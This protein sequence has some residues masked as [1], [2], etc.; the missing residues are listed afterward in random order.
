[1][2]SIIDK[3][4]QI[5]AAIFGKDVRE[6][7]ASGIEVI[8]SEVESTTSKQNNLKSQFDSLVINAGSSNAE[9]VAG[10]TSNTTGLTSDTIG[11]RIDGVDSQL[12]DIKN[13]QE[14]EPEDLRISISDTDSVLVQRAF[15]SCF[16]ENRKYKSIKLGRM[17]NIDTSIQITGSVAPFIFIK[18]NGGGLSNKQNNPMFIGA[19]AYAGGLHFDKVK[20][21][22]D[23]VYSTSAYFD[24]T[25]LIQIVLDGCQFMGTPT[26]LYSPTYLQSCR[27]INS[28]FKGMKDYQV[29][30]L[31][32]YDV[33][34]DNNLVEWGDGGLINLT[35]QGTTLDS[36]CSYGLKI[37]KN[38]MEGIHVQSPIKLTSNAS[39]LI[40][41]NYFEGNT[42]FDID[43]SG[44]ELEHQQITVRDNFFGSMALDEQGQVIMRSGAV[45]VGKIFKDSLKG[46]YDFS[47]NN[48]MGAV[49]FDFEDATASRNINLSKSMH[50][51][52]E[53]S[54]SNL[55]HKG[56]YG[57]SVRKTLS[58]DSLSHIFRYAFYNETLATITRK[59]FLLELYYTNPTYPDSVAKTIGYLHIVPTTKTGKT[60][61]QLKL[62]FK[63]I[64]IYNGGT[65]ESESNGITDSAT[66]SYILW[67]SNASFWRDT[68]TGATVLNDSI[69]I[70]VESPYTSLV[71]HIT[72]MPNIVGY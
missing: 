42:T 22:G 1:M 12:A 9:L 68:V 40:Q 27:I 49:I 37:T 39:C 15:N 59:V 5:R 13:Y 60:G 56:F 19:N 65:S 34:L 35:Q 55:T 21:Q 63:P 25:N 16:G 20:F 14:I 41:G 53:N 66:Y 69:R 44:G 24:C 61:S 33:V 29:K 46:S 62:V 71:G 18:G 32:V 23:S 6:N 64:L 7:I 36:Y 70:T 4:A 58:R 50:L 30:A 54:I 17:Y 48:G 31:R 47:A 52:S 51:G 67:D 57:Q 11:H 2:A 8:N 10:R 28:N 45:K 3:V 38:V 72:E 26:I 43:M